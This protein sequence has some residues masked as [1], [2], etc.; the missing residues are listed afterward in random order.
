V[1]LLV[2]AMIVALAT[3]TQAVTGFGLA[4]VSMPL[5]VGMIGIRQAAPLIALVGIASQVI[6]IIRYRQRVVWGDIRELA[7]GSVIGIPLGVLALTT[8]SETLVT[9]ILGVA[10]LGYAVYALTA[11]DRPPPRLKGGPVAYGAGLAGGLLTG[12]Y[13]SGGP[14]LVI[15]GSARRWSP[16][17]FKG[18]I[19]ALLVVHSLTAIVSHSVAGNMTASVFELFVVMVPVLS[20]AT[21]AGF[22]LD[23]Y[24]DARRFHQ[25]VLVL[26]IL[27]GM[28]L[29]VGALG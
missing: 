1:E 25:L 2:I 18:N 11:A 17:T 3:F 23:R 6:M 15:Y 24:I 22:A 14:P 13:N 20:L 16:L 7:V 19:Q 9:L 28:R 10:I 27:L 5:L 8:V 21:L 4:L 29:I 26:L 12:A